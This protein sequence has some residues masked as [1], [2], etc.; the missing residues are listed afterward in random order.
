MEMSWLLNSYQ[1]YTTQPD[2]LL[3]QWSCKRMLS[4]GAKSCSPYAVHPL[5][6]R[7]DAHL[8]GFSHI[9]YLGMWV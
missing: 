1:G 9:P 8:Q 5:I 3:Q 6:R 7:A 4:A 2:Y